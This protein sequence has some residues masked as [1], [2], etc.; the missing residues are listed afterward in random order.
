MRGLP[1]LLLAVLIL[2]VAVYAGTTTSSGQSSS[3]SSG[4]SSSTRSSASTSTL[5]I[6]ER[7]REQNRLRGL[8]S[9][10]SSRRSTSSFEGSEVL[11][12][13]RASRSSSS[14]GGSEVLARIRAQ[15][16]SH[17]SV[18]SG[19]GILARIRERNAV[20]AS[21]GT[22]VAAPRSRSGRCTGRDI[23][24]AFGP[25]TCG[26][27]IA[28]PGLIWGDCPV[29]ACILRVRDTDGDFGGPLNFD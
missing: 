3:A 1:M 23:I 26:S 15:R 12:R 14:F 17:S 8:N 9:S 5:S 28:V 25:L 22:N 13:I 24:D 18:P 11:A 4:R 2:P 29:S 7:I 21:Q 27:G 19:S 20:E 16:S 10:A 6:L